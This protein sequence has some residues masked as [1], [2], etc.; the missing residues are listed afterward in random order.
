MSALLALFL[1][2]SAAW[3]G[4]A[5]PSYPSPDMPERERVMQVVGAHF[6]WP[7]AERDF[8]LYRT[9]EICGEYVEARWKLTRWETRGLSAEDQA[10]LSALRGALRDWNTALHATAECVA[11][12]GN[13]WGKMEW[14]EA[15][16]L[17]DAVAALGGRLVAAARAPGAADAEFDRRIRERI[18]AAK[19]Y[20]VGP[21]EAMPAA[22]REFP[23]AHAELVRRND[24]LA[25]ILA[26]FSPED[27][28]GVR[29]EMDRLVGVIEE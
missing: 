14:V 26:E 6:L 21:G 15:V 17:E 1:M 8:P 5:A 29:R 10:R 19:P 20:A 4:P 16:R 12:G 25:G 22:A 7:I 24:V 27:T 23:K 3:A 9:A 2:V 28:R 18:A 11:G 13:G